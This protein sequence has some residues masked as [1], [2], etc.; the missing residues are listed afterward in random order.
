MG[1]TGSRNAEVKQHFRRSRQ[2][3]QQKTLILHQTRPLA[4][5]KRFKTIYCRARVDDVRV[6]PTDVSKVVRVTFKRM[7]PAAVFDHLR[8]EAM[9]EGIDDCCPDTA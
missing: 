2:A 3:D 7:V 1:W 6:A 9:R 4:S 5:S 8:T